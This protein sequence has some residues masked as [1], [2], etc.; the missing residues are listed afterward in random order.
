MAYLWFI[1]VYFIVV[2]AVGL[3]S[4]RFVKSADG[5]FVA[6]RRSGTLF[7]AGS[8]IA[9]II[10]GSATVG[11]A[12]KGFSQGITGIWWLLVGSIGLVILGVFLA[13]KLRSTSLYT[14]PELAEHQY[15]SR[16]SLV[17][18]IL[19][20]VA[21]IG[22]IAAQ[23]VAAGTIMSIIGIGSKTVW[24]IA[25]TGVFVSYTLV[26]GQHANIRTDIFQ[27]IV[28]FAGIITAIIVVMSSV[29]GWNGLQ[30]SLPADRFSFPLSANFDG[31][32]LLSWLLLVG[33]TYVIGPDMY[34]RLFCARD[35]KTARNSVL[36]VAVLIIPFA[37]CIVLLGMSAAALF[38]A[39]SPEQAL[40][41]L[42]KDQLPLFAGGL[43]LAALMGATMSS[44][45]TCLM[46]TGTI[47]SVDIIK[48]FKPSLGNKETVLVA[49]ISIVVIGVLSLL[50]AL[51]LGGIISSLLF[52]Y[53]VYTGGVIIPVFAGF[54]KDRLKVTSLGAI[55]AIIGG[56]VTA[57][58]SKLFA[59]KYLD[60]GA[61]AVSAL[62]LF[63]VS[64]L[65]RKY[66]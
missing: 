15:D 5:F 35:E 17:S 7:I 50:L 3:L 8:L 13:R 49:R 2:V 40:P 48:K 18:S 10:G 63:A 46:S 61:F 24:M 54:Y 47:L 21:W 29:G 9:T 12:G 30:A 37:F 14:L 19:I 33:L 38:P 45:D 57:V 23:I 59:V 60:L 39:I 66:R 26:G 42:V 52:A 53:T 43:V 20:V 36:W 22:V 65:D 56:G 31:I 28:I 27:S 6:G 51:R 25:F 55:T 16:V 11:M 58:M 64:Y 34:S 32:D 44:A 41:T 62:L 4:R 1:V